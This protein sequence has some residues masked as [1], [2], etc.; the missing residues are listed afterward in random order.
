[1]TLPFGS[2]DTCAVCGVVSEQTGVL[3]TSTFGAPDLDGRPAEMKRS[4]I[5]WWVHRCPG[6]GYCAP[7][8]DEAPADAAD[9][10]RSAPYRQQLDDPLTPE[11]A[12]MFLCSAM[13]V[14]TSGG[15]VARGLVTPLICAAWACDDAGAVDVAVRCRLRRPAFSAQPTPSC[16]RSWSFS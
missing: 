7:S 3:S 14:E 8:I 9:L 11:L 10:V 6:C 15:P 1:M 4:T 5:G 2:S 12:R 16:A 13:I